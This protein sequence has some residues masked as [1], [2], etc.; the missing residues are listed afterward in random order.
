MVAEPI[1]GRRSSETLAER[2][3]RE[4]PNVANHLR[5]PYGYAARAEWAVEMMKTH[6]QRKCECGYWVI[7]ERK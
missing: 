6:V 5:G 3:K 7:W 1:V 2:E 4:C